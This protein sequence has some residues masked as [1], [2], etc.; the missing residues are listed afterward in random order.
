M[1]DAVH[2]LKHIQRKVIQSVRKEQNAT[3]QIVNGVEYPQ[4][5]GIRD[6]IQQKRKKKISTG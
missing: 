6:Q 5:Y 2:H 1:K 3:E 4:S